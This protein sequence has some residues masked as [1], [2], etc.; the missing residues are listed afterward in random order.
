MSYFLC[1]LQRSGT[2]LTETIMSKNYL[3]D[4]ARYGPE[5]L[6]SHWKHSLIVPEEILYDN[7]VI[8]HKNPYTWIESISFR[9]PVDFKS[10]QRMFPADQVHEDPDYMI[11]AKYSIK[12]KSFNLINLAKTWNAFHTN[13]VLNSNLE[14]KNVAI[15]KY[16][17]LLDKDKRNAVIESIG[18]SFNYTQRTPEI[19]FPEKGSVPGS[20]RYDNEI[21]EYYKL[22]VPKFLTKKQISAVNEIIDPKIM[23]ILGYKFIDGD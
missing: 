2:N 3:A 18:R 14:G 21:E 23:T 20:K 6:G 9:D 1:G 7:V 13:W 12:R 17:D 19:I 11:G 8:I 22:G 5:G 16:E 10:S 4:S 15:I